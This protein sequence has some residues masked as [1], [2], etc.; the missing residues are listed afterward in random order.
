MIILNV[1]ATAAELP[2]YDE[3]LGICFYPLSHSPTGWKPILLA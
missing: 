2:S 1:L 3:G